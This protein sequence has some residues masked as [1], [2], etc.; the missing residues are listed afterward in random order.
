MPERLSDYILVEAEGTGQGLSLPA[1]FV[2]LAR[3]IDNDRVLVW[4]QL[5]ERRPNSRLLFHF[6]E[7]DSRTSVKGLVVAK[8][9]LK[10]GSVKSQNQCP[11][12]RF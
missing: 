12:C 5:E 10:L 8:P 11:V 2:Q 3:S 1:V 7:S 6:T 4:G 9:G